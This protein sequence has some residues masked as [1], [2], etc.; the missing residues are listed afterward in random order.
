MFSFDSPRSLHN[1]LE[2]VQEIER[3]RD[4]KPYGLLLVGIY[5]HNHSRHSYVVIFFSFS[6]SFSQNSFAIK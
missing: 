5:Y 1:L 3:V 6:F 4:G 2:L